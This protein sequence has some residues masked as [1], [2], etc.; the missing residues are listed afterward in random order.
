[1]E[2]EEKVALWGVKDLFQGG[3]A[4]VS[5]ASFFLWTRKALRETKFF[6]AATAKR[7][8]KKDPMLKESARLYINQN[9]RGVLFIDIFCGVELWKID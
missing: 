1:M 7:K 5:S 6:Y 8:E 4:W 9:R 2:G 3:G